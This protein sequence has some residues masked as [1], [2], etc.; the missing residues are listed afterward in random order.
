MASTAIELFADLDPGHPFF[1]QLSFM[2]A[3][4]MPDYQVALTRVK[5]SH[6]N[7]L[8]E[9]DKLMFVRLAF[10]YIEPRHRMGLL[11]DELRDRI[12]KARQAFREG[13]PQELKTVIEFY[14]PDAYNC[15]SSVQD[16]ILMGRIA[17]GVAEGKKTIQGLLRD[18]LDEHELYDE[19]FTVGLDFEVGVSGK[20]LTAAQRQKLGLARALIKRPDF[21]IVNRSLAALDR[22][23]Q[24]KIITQIVE[25]GPQSGAAGGIFWVLASPVLAKKFDRVLVMDQGRVIEDGKPDELIKKQ[26]KFAK[27]VS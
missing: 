16:N 7:E 9:D 2:T 15:A 25:H 24:E 12:V 14:D 4:E 27:L 17:Y 26:G 6:F 8:N 23:G 19:V 11:D 18:V 10:D 1:E 3:E 20:R 22:P 5:G 21:L 13:L